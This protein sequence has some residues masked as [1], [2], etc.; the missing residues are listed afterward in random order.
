MIP[1]SVPSRGICLCLGLA[2]AFLLL[3]PALVEPKPRGWGSHLGL[4]LP[5]CPM[6]EVLGLPCP[7]CGV[8]TAW[9]LLLRGRLSEGLRVHP[10]ALALHLALTALA[11]SLLW[12]GSGRPNP[13]L[14]AFWRRQ[15]AFV[16]TFASAFC[17]L[18]ILRLAGLWP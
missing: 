18:W 13:L 6:R 9:A 17:L 1:P 10:V 11:A 8:T 4:G 15:G 16:I 12:E 3:L 14:R 7:T 5:P 2:L